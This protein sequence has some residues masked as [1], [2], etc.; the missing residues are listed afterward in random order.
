MN[1]AEIT[2]KYVGAPFK[3]GGQSRADGFDCFTLVFC[4]AR[5]LGKRVP[6]EFD[7][8]TLDNYPALYAT[9]ED[10]AIEKMIEFAE[11]NCREVPISSAFVGDLLIMRDHSGGRFAAL[12]AG[13]DFI[14]S[15]FTNL[16]VSIA[17]IRTFVLDRVFKWEKF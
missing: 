11:A 6:D 17:R 10:A 13:N 9:S 2:S 16:G 15:S 14:I 7:G 4:L 8:L 12:H 5:D 3:I 1:L